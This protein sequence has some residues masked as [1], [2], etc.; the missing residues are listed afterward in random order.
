M[1]SSCVSISWPFRKNFLMKCLELGWIEHIQKQ[2]G[3][4]SM[5]KHRLIKPKIRCFYENSAV[6]YF[7]FAAL[8]SMNNCSKQHQILGLIIHTNRS[9]SLTKRF[10]SESKW[11]STKD[12]QMALYKQSF[13]LLLLFSSAFSASNPP[14]SRCDL[15]VEKPSLLFKILN[16]KNG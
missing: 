8:H 2:L 15:E 13:S 11:S 12:S 5:C 9:A 3:K 14:P 6:Y 7:S 10:P 4:P 16:L 1:A